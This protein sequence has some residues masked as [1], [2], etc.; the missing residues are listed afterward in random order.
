[1]NQLSHFLEEEKSFEQKVENFNF[2]R[3][4]KSGIF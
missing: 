1:L 4:L 2:I 3:F